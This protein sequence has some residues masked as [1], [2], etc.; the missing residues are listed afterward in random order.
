MTITNGVFTNGVIYFEIE[1]V[2]FETKSLTRH[3]GK[4]SGDVING[5]ME[6]E[7]NDEERVIDWEATRV[8]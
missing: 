7:I 4:I 6:S 3:I 5:T 1:R 8:D 2:F